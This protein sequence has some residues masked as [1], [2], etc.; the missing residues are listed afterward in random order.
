MQGVEFFAVISFRAFLLEFV[1]IY[2]TRYIFLCKIY[3]I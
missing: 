2:G 3:A 1:N